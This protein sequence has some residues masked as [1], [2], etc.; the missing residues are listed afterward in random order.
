MLKASPVSLCTEHT[1][2][3]PSATSESYLQKQ[4]GIFGSRQN[5]K[6]PVQWILKL[7]SYK[8]APQYTQPYHFL[9]AVRS[10]PAQ[11]SVKH[12]SQ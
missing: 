3:T 2:H 1:V 10:H 11:Y 5:G 6:A 4:G 7:M 8:A 12:S 9:P